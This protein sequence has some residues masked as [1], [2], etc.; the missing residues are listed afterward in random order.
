MNWVEVGA[1]LTFDAAGVLLTYWA[2]GLGRR[3]Q[4]FGIVAAGLIVAVAPRLVTAPKPF[5]R[6]V[7]ALIST[8]L[9]AK[10]FDLGIGATRPGAK[11]PGW[12]AYLAFLPNIFG[13]VYRTLNTE[14]SPPPS[15]D[16]ARLARGLVG[17]AAGLALIVGVFQ[18]D[19]SRWPLAVEHPVKV[20]ALFAV[21]LA[22][23]A[24]GI[25]LWRLGGG[26]GR[27]FMRLPFLATTPAD[28]WRRYNRPV[29]HFLRENVYRTAGARESRVWA[30][31]GVFLV[32]AAAHEYLFAVTLG[33]VEGFQSAFF[34]SQGIAV[35]ATQRLRPRGRLAVACGVATLA[36]NLA[37]SLLFFASVGGVMPFYAP[38]RPGWL[39][40]RP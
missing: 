28:F 33:R 8:T 20:L 25:S 1:A 12:W 11:R 17:A 30:T 6:F 4:R 9:L 5:P 40:P 7:L 22:L 38:G 32:S 18:V 3:G 31:L 16:R 36:F 21:L 13:L 19:W 39:R 29:G 23:D 27:Q 2:L 35:A 34:L 37:T 10:F 14:P 24:V 15:A 26:R